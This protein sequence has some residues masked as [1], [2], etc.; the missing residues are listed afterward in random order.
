MLIPGFIVAVPAGILSFN[1]LKQYHV[2]LG[3][4]GGIAAGIAAF[5]IGVL[6]VHYASRTLEWLIAMAHKCPECG[7]KKWS[8]PFTEGFGL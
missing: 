3:L 4:A 8:Y 5:I 6:V 1:M 7:K 2:L